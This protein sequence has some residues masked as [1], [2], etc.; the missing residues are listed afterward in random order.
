MKSF[1]IL[2]FLLFGYLFAFDS[3]AQKTELDNKYTPSKTSP[4]NSENR[5][6][7]SSNGV[8]FNNSISLELLALAR[9]GFVIT[10][11][12]NVKDGFSAFVSIGP[13]PLKDFIG[14]VF[15]NG[16]SDFM[17]GEEKIGQNELSGYFIYEAPFTY[18]KSSPIMQFGVRILDDDYLNGRGLE[19]MYRTYNETFYIPTQNGT[20]S[21]GDAS[22]EIYTI[23]DYSTK[24][25]SS[26]L[27]LG[28][29]YQK[30][31]NRLAWG[32]STGIGLRVNNMPQL[33][34]EKN[35]NSSGGF[36]ENYTLSVNE[37]ARETTVVPTLLLTF[38]LGFGL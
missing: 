14:A 6:K 8:N 34:I 37:R 15:N 21:F 30:F 26:M 1:L 10:Y 24:I 19:I 4:Y 9:G 7:K 17:I 13:K 20:S 35:I 12:R 25:K 38:N 28:Y 32:L 33:E 22:E 31:S 36:V 2:P 29:R 3:L 23:K 16:S 27:Y 18:S 11:E 5:D